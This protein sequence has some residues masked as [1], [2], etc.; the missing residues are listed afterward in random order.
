MRTRI[1]KRLEEFK[2]VTDELIDE[3]Y[4]LDGS[5]D[6]AA[7]I[8]GPGYEYH[9]H[10]PTLNIMPLRFSLSQRLRKRYESYWQA[11]LKQEETS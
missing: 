4:I 11:F 5:D 7:V 3:N 8:Y 1:A 9:N 2:D 10:I 6:Q